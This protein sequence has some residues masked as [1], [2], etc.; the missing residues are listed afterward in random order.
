M[1]LFRRREKIKKLGL[2][3][4]IIGVAHSQCNESNW[5]EYYNS[6][7]WN[8]EYC[9]LAYANLSGENLSSAWLWGA[10]LSGADL[11][12]ANLSGA[13]LTWA[14]LAWGDCSGADF[15][16][17]DL[18]GADFL[19]ANLD[20]ACLEGA[21]GFTQT[22]FFGSPIVEGCA[23]SGECLFEDLDGDSYDDDS[24]TNGFIA[25]YG[26]GVVVGIDSVDITTDNEES[27]N[28][29]FSEGQASV[30][31]NSDGLV[32][33]FPVI[34]I[35]D[36]NAQ[37]L[38]QGS[39]DYYIDSGATCFDQE[40]GDLSH[41]VWVSGDVVNIS[42]PNTYLVSYNC[43]DSDGNAAETKHRTVFVIDQYLFSDEDEDSY[44][45]DSYSAGVQSGDITG[46]GILN[47]ADL[48]AYIN[49]ILNK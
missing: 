33:E 24:Y 48:I 35:I 36:G 39:L 6:D 26:E 25:G 22:N 43:S 49:I 5:Q 11:V 37:A 9:D 2:S 28:L 16:E 21:T 46:D 31:T 41:N 30:D 34:S 32:D 4:L 19:G 45:D 38:I 1:H 14:N 15:S 13:T 42:S 3:I 8:M 18:S 12:G 47:V 44:D 20:E 10:N 7:G 23:E 17:A 29:G 40:D 27:Y